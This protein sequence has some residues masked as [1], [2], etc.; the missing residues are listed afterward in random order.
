MFQVLY[1][2]LP[3]YEYLII[4]THPFCLK[5]LCFLLSY[6]YLRLIQKNKVSR[7]MS[8][9]LLWWWQVSTMEEVVARRWALVVL[10][11]PPPA[12]HSS[13]T[14]QDT[15][16]NSTQGEERVQLCMQGMKENWEDY[17]YYLTT[18]VILACRNRLKSM[19][20]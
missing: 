4:I 17:Y 19:Q 14:T 2:F 16:T 3:S 13:S 20:M 6:D 15:N 8:G 7:L 10:R 5:F 1:V 9:D 18:E 12:Q 11:L